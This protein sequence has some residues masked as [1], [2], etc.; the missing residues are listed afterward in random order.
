MTDAKVTE[1]KIQCSITDRYLSSVILVV[2]R[3]KVMEKRLSVS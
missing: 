3:K 1:D 2:I